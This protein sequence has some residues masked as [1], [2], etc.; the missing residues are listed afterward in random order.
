MR[1]QKLTYICI[2]R[3]LDTDPASRTA[4]FGSES[5]AVS[6]RVELFK[7]GQL[8][9]R[10]SDATIE[11]VDVPTDKAGLLVWLNSNAAQA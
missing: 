8:V 9:G 2:A 4:W 10:K 5:E 6:R 3:E 11:A 1:F 7:S